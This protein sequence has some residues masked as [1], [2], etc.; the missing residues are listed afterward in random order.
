M[1]AYITP[2]ITCRE[3]SSL[4]VQNCLWILAEEDT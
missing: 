2:V 1:L 4:L 3:I